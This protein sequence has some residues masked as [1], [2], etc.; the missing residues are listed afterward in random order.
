MGCGASKREP[1]EAELQRPHP[2][3]GDPQPPQKSVDPEPKGGDAEGAASEAQPQPASRDNLPPSQ[4]PEGEASQSTPP[5]EEGGTDEQAL[6]AAAERG[7]E[8]EVLRLLSLP[9][10]DPNHGRGEGCARCAARDER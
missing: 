6:Y 2:P 1:P 8:A 10:I 3:G 5:K 7:D 4:Q 9:S